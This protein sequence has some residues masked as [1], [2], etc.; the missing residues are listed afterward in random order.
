MHF[1][2]RPSCHTSF[3]RPCRPW[4][5]CLSL[6]HSPTASAPAATVGIWRGSKPLADIAHAVAFCSALFGLLKP[7]VD[8]QR[9]TPEPVSFCSSSLQKLVSYQQRI[10]EKHAKQH[11]N[12]ERRKRKELLVLAQC[13]LSRAELALTSTCECERMK[14][15]LISEIRFDTLSRTSVT[16]A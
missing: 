11:Q 9:L 12:A 2:C 10:K 13:S 7:P 6:A 14:L 5:P 15:F 8:R 3:F 1:I 4:R 16:T